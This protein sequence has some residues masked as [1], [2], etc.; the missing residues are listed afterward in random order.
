MG[1]TPH[2]HAIAKVNHPCDQGL[3]A[4][5]GVFIDTFVV[6]TINA[7]VIIATGANQIDGLKGIKVTQKSI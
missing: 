4:I 2:A 7:L 1:S 5:V 6:L 3:V